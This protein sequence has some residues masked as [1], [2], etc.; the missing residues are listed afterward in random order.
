MYSFEGRI[1]YS[2]CDDRLR[3]S[4]P[5]AMNYLQDCSMFHCE[6]IGHGQAFYD[7]HGFVWLFAA[8][9]IRLLRLPSYCEDIRVST[10]C[11]EMGATLARRQFLM[12]TNEGERLIEAEALCVVVNTT[13]GR[14]IR[15]PEAERAF[16]TDEP[17]VGLPP[18]KR[19]I[20]LVGEGQTLFE[21]VVDHGLLDSNE[22]VNNVKYVAIAEEAVRLREPDFR[23]GLIFVQY[24]VAAHLGDVMRAVVRDEEA[25]HSVDLC[26]PDGTSYAV[27]RMLRG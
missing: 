20:R 7:E 14:A 9:Q 3:L 4:I 25:G 18:T 22:H 24:K 6:H 17:A 1:R 12:Q 26:S 23:P 13:T 16:V 2:E 11:N 10:W 19:K 21:R 15:V 8:W 27:V 5:A